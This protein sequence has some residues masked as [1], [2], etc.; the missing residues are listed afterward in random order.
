MGVQ[1]VIEV[2]AMTAGA[3]AT[4]V[5]VAVAAEVA[6]T[7]VVIGKGVVAQESGAGQEVELAAGVGVAGGT[8]AVWTVCAGIR[9]RVLNLVLYP[10]MRTTIQMPSDGFPLPTQ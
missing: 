9:A 7:T 3:G 6:A 5:A 4:I 2:G 8:R 10:A 1:G